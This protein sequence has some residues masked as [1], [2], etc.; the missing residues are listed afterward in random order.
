MSI[1]TRPLNGRP[2]CHYCGQCGRGCAAHANFSTPSVLLPPALETGR[3]ELV[4]NAMAHEVTTDEEGLATGIS[5]VDKRDGRERH[6]KSRIVV[7]AASACETARLLLNSKSTRHPNGL[8]NSSDAV[9]RYL[10]DSTGTSAM[11]YFPRLADGVPH[12]E[13]GANGLHLYMPWWRDNRELDFPRGYHIEFGGG[14]RMPSYGFLD[15]IEKTPLGGGYGQA[16]KDNYRKLYGAR[17]V[18]PDAAR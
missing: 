3:L 1:L 15:G 2:A 12:N 10:M 18:F 7:L 13:D 8:A 11:G 9:G 4:T 16:L 6:V 14:R 5:Y 17:S